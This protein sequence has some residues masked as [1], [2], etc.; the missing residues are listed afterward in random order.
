MS[1]I[2]WRYLHELFGHRFQAFHPEKH[3]FITR[4]AWLFVLHCDS[5]KNLMSLI[6]PPRSSPNGELWRLNIIASNFAEIAA[7][8]QEGRGGNTLHLYGA[9]IHALFRTPRMDFE[10]KIFESLDFSR[11]AVAEVKQGYAD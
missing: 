10:P 8:R 11:A 3:E 6:V 5:Q 2:A 7:G 4:K 9:S 1:C